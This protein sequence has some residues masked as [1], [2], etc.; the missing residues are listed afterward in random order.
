MHQRQPRSLG[1]PRPLQRGRRHH[2]QRARLHQHQQ[3]HVLPGRLAR[4]LSPKRRLQ[5]AR[6]RGGAHRLPDATVRERAARP[7]GERH[8]SLPRLRGRHQQ[9]MPRGRRDVPQRLPAG[10]AERA[11]RIL[12]RPRVHRQGPHLP[13]HRAYPAR[14]R[15]IPLISTRPR[16]RAR[17]QDPCSCRQPNERPRPFTQC[18]YA[19]QIGG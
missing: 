10:S 14:H 5:T 1:L 11:A 3:S 12:R 2:L 19:T 6:Q 7:H 17:S 15:Q 18:D 16:P 8:P 4:R 9:G 13:G